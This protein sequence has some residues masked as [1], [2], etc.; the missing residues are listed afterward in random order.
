MDL[1]Q[2]PELPLYQCHKVVH[3]ARIIGVAY[4]NDP[5]PEGC[6]KGLPDR[7]VL[8]LELPEGNYPLTLPGLFVGKHDPQVGGYYVKYADGFESYSPAKAFE[9]GYE[10]LVVNRKPHLA[11]HGL[12]FGCA[13]VWMRRGL[14]VGRQAW[15]GDC[16]IILMPEMQLPPFSDQTTNRK[17]N[18][19]TAKYIGE[20]TPF[21]SRPYFACWM[22]RFG[23]WQPGFAFGTEDLLATDWE[24]I[25]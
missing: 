2:L 15:R 12:D 1:Q 9:D 5:Q 16:H 8:T 10:P 3:S 11:K 25:E 20:D 21:N 6:A 4:E 24:V 23:T 18:D 19:R 7:V 13:L 14:K 22:P 17:V